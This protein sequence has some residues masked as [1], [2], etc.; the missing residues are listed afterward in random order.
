MY[1]DLNDV[2]YACAAIRNLG[3][4]PCTSQWSHSVVVLSKRVARG[5]HQHYNFDNFHGPGYWDG[6]IDRARHEPFGVSAELGNGHDGAR[7]LHRML[8]A[9]SDISQRIDELVTADDLFRNYSLAS[10]KTT[11]DGYRPGYGGMTGI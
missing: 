11:V 8:S 6:V 5:V 2:Q 10:P 1:P 9:V 7:Q 3:E 4:R